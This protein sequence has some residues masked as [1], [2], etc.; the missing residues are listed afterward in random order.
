MD[1]PSSSALWLV[2]ICGIPFLIAFLAPRRWLLLATLAW[3]LLP[4]FVLL[5]FLLVE[6]VRDPGAL[7]PKGGLVDALAFIFWLLI[8]PMLV[9][10]AISLGVG[11]LLRWARNG[12]R[13][14]P[15]QPAA[16]AARRAPNSAP[17]AAARPLAAPPPLPAVEEPPPEGRSADGSLRFE[18]RHEGSRQVDLTAYLFVAATGELLAR[19]TGWMTS[20]I[21]P[22]DGGA[23]LL[24]LAHHDCDAL[25][26]IDPAT[27][28][29]RAIGEEGPAQP[30]SR[31]AEAV[32]HSLS[33]CVAMQREGRGL[34]LSPDGRMRVELSAAEWAPTQ[35]VL[36]PRVKDA[37]R[38]LLDLSGTDWDAAVHFPRDGVVSLGL[39][40]Y[41]SGAR[42]R[43]D[44]DAA[45]G[46]FALWETDAPPLTGA[47]ADL[48]PAFE[49]AADRASRSVPAGAPRPAPRVTRRGALAAVVI[50]AGALGAIAAAAFVTA[51]LRPKPMPMRPTP[52][53]KP[54][55][56][57]SQPPLGR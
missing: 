26:L 20:R 47:L 39:R 53:P 14:A 19:G 34:E 12:G 45:R 4:V 42:L 22:R 8:V 25:F 57:I 2:V 55:P 18:N 40:S 27:W 49:A 28:S 51:K 35:W 32:A 38:T 44:I 1:F 5:L 21:V 24:S 16:P 33:A 31:L 29:F 15:P 11:L 54:P 3:L 41:R 56:R 7:S 36:S 48:K 52:P 6:S 30:L 37:G 17:A 23:L 50:L 46:G 43:L 10:T 9:V 13:L